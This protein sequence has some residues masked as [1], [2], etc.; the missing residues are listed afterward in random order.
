M[1]NF[2]LFVEK[3]QQVRVNSNYSSQSY[4]IIVVILKD[5]MQQNTG[6]CWPLYFVL[7]LFGIPNKIE[8]NLYFQ[9]SKPILNPL[10]QYFADLHG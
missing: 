5:Q 2:L 1:I 4:H 7:T 6:S 10:L 3:Y 8:K 9:K